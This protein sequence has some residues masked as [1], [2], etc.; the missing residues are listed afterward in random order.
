[1]GAHFIFQIIFTVI[2]LSI[3]TAFVISSLRYH[4]LRKFLLE[5]NDRCYD[6][7]KEYHSKSAV[8]V[9]KKDYNEFEALTKE[10]H[11]MLSVWN[12]V[13]IRVYSIN[14][15]SA[16]TSLMKPIKYESWFS[17]EDAR[18]LKGLDEEIKSNKITKN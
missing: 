3:A 1:M 7:I 12:R 2:N 15:F 13:I 17:E 6:K 5:I 9:M 4:H 18:I 16:L 10:Y 11:K 14:Q 8:A